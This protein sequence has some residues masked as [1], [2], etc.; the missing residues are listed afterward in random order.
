MS[1]T[2]ARMAK[3]EPG[4]DDRYHLPLGEYMEYCEMLAGHPIISYPAF[5]WYR[6]KKVV[7][8]E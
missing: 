8:D 1:L 7:C 5:T 3:K 2:F 6:G 4:A